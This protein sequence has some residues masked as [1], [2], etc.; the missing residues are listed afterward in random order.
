MFNSLYIIH[1]R[2]SVNHVFILY[3]VML[4]KY[5]FKPNHY[6]FTKSNQVVFVPKPN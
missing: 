5:Y 2:V 1:D 4:S 6:V 3:P